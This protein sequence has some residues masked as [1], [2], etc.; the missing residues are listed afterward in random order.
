MENRIVGGMAEK[1]K[2]PKV[3]VVI[4]VY[5][6]E[7]TIKQCLDSVFNQDYKN[8]EV[9]IVDNNSTDRT[10]E[11]IKEFQKKSKNKKIRYLFEEK[12]GRGAARYKGEINSRGHVILTTDSDCI[13]PE[14]WI[15]EMTEPILNNKEV[16]VQ[17]VIKSL[18][19]NYWA[20]NIQKEIDAIMAR[21]KKGNK[22]ETVMTGNFAIKKSILKKIGY[23]DQ[24]LFDVDD[25][26]IG[27]R[28]R[29]KGYGVHFKDIAVLH[30]HP[31]S[32]FKVFMK[33]YGKGKWNAKIRE[34]H[35]SEKGIFK[36]RNMANHLEFVKGIIGESL[37][38]NKALAYNLISGIAWRAGLFAGWLRK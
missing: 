37:T 2:T 30:P 13:V 33:I 38:F 27:V 9:I 23:T 21:N 1:M 7:K 11:I 32:L 14:D 34:I 35:K 29:I 16:A 22:I 12:R 19:S 4:P 3:S 36:K 10:K 17:G 24:N 8:Y 31:D 20:D 18:F 15:K 5:N 28:L 25:T 26:E 6:G